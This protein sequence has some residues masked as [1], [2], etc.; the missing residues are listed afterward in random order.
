MKFLITARTAAGQ[1]TYPAIG[2]RN[3][4]MDAAYAAGALGVTILVLP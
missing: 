4:L 2:D 3:Q 1:C